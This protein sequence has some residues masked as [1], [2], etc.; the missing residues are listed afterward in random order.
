MD[1]SAWPSPQMAEELIRSSDVLFPPSLAPPHLTVEGMQTHSG[2]HYH[3][4]GDQSIK[5]HQ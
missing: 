5:V 2:H 4:D 3:C 1:S